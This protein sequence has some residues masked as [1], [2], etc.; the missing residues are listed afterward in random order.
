MEKVSWPSFLWTRCSFIIETTCSV[1][2]CPLWCVHRVY[3]VVLQECLTLVHGTQ[4]VA[5][6]C[7]D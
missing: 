5:Q 2:A 7:L 3:Y 4:Q 6:K 1:L